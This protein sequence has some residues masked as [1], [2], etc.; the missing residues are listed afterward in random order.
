[1]SNGQSWVRGPAALRMLFRTCGNCRSAMR[2]WRIEPKPAEHRVDTHFFA[3]DTC[4]H[5]ASEDIARPE[6]G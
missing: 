1:M 5:A 4:G 6:R 3:C 2:L